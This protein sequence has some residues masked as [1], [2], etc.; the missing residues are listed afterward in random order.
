MRTQKITTFEDHEFELCRG[1]HLNSIMARGGRVLQ[2]PCPSPDDCASFQTDQLEAFISHTWKLNRCLK[3]LALSLHFNLIAATTIHTLLVMALGLLAVHGWLPAFQYPGLGYGYCCKVFGIPVFVLLL[4]F[5]REVM[6][7]F[8]CK[9]PLVF[10]DKTCIN[11][12]DQEL[13]LKGI[14]KLSA[15][16]MCARTMVVVY[17]SDYLERL[18]TVYELASFL[19]YNESL[20]AIRLVTIPQVKTFFFLLTSIYVVGLLD[21]F[22][23]IT[24]DVN[25]TVW[26]YAPFLSGYL[27][28]H[29]RWS[30][31]Q[32]SLYK[33]CQGFE[34]DK[35]KCSMTED[36]PLV[37]T[38]IVKLMRWKDQCFTA[39]EGECFRSFEKD[40]RDTLSTKL[41]AAMGSVLSYEQILGACLVGHGPCY[42]DLMNSQMRPRETAV[43]VAIELLWIFVLLP[44]IL[45]CSGALA[46][47]FPT[48]Q[49]G[50]EV[51][52]ICTASIFGALGPATVANKLDSFW[53]REA[54]ISD[55][56]LAVLVLTD[57]FGAIFV[58]ATLGGRTRLQRKVGL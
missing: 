47:C 6:Q 1:S 14:K 18:W 4:L 9:G 29:R 50:W 54:L 45:F 28:L 39:D 40:V 53:G 56:A 17:C 42:I 37:Q 22:A 26:V 20:H 5:G 13:K 52:W 15:F 35:C 2:S 31:Q 41:C 12:V 33:S 30:A 51:I 46:C 58:A 8:G 48:W 36:I 49:R 23:K 57:C 16:V 27:Y 38:N 10:L 43:L 3:F 25:L 55:A 11:Q 32:V 24:L 34:L 44:L 7:L 19:A 21:V